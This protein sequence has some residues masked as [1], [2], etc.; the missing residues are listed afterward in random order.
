M[1]LFVGLFIRH[2]K[3]CF[4]TPTQSFLG[5]VIN[6]VW[7]PQLHILETFKK[8]LPEN[9]DERQKSSVG[10]SR[11][12][13]DQVLVSIIIR[14]SRSFDFIPSRKATVSIQIPA[15]QFFSLCLHFTSIIFL[16]YNS[17]FTFTME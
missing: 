13:S 9:L 1:F 6:H 2:R 8:Y 7:I 17:L 15:S 11:S 14:L 4:F 10:K 3:G 12:I 16:D 5:I